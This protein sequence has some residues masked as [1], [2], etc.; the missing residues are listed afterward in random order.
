MYFL[1]LL[2]REKSET[3]DILCL[4]IHPVN[5]ILEAR[6]HRLPPELERRRD[7]PALGRPRLLGGREGQGGGKLERLQPSS[8]SVGIDAIEDGL[9]NL[10]KKLAQLIC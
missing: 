3:L 10:E 1:Y 8:R 5:V 2:Q 7:E 6:L 9:A 4:L